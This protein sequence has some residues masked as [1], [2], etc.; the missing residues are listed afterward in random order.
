[1]AMCHV[2]FGSYNQCIALHESS[3]LLTLGCANRSQVVLTASGT[4][5]GLK[6]LRLKEIMDQA[7]VG[8]SGL[9]H[10]AQIDALL[11]RQHLHF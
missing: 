4:K 7:I 5:R 8:G 3:P 10:F 6:M 1:M 11:F 2:T 9:K